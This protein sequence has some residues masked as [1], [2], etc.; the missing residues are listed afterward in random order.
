VRVQAALFD[1]GIGGVPDQLLRAFDGGR[2]PEAVERRK[3]K[4]LRADTHEV[5]GHIVVWADAGEAYFEDGHATGGTVVMAR[6]YEKGGK[7]RIG[8]I[9]EATFVD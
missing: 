5:N 4:V 1:H 8:M 3:V 2:E 6:I 7:R 9:G